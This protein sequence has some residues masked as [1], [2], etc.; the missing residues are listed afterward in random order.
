MKKFLTVLLALSV[1]FTYTVGTAFAADEVPGTTTTYQQKL[2]AAVTDLAKDLLS[3]KSGTIENLAAK[4]TETA[5]DADGHVVTLTIG[6][7]VYENV[8][9][10]VYT[11]YAK[12]LTIAKTQLEKAYADADAAG[13]EALNALTATEV[14]E[15]LIGEAVDSSVAKY[16]GMKIDDADSMAEF[17]ALV[18]STGGKDA[19]KQNAFA[20]AFQ[21]E[22][23]SVI[24]ELNKIDL[25]LYTDDVMDAEHDS[26]KTTYAQLAKNT[27]EEMI[28]DAGKIVIESDASVQTIA[29]QVY[30]LQNMIGT[31][32]LKVEEKYTGLDGNEIVVSYSLVGVKLSVTVGANTYETLLQTKEE[33]KNNDTSLE[34]QKLA[35]KA[36]AQAKAAQFYKDALDAY[37]ADKTAATKAIFDKAVTEKDA[38]LEV[39]LFRIDQLTS[40]PTATEFTYGSFNGT[41]TPN[42]DLVTEY[43]ALVDFAA[44]AKKMVEKDG[45]LTYDASKVD[46]NLAAAKIKVYDRNVATTA[47]TADIIANAKNEV[48]D[49]EFAK[50]EAVAKLESERDAKLYN[51]DD[52]DKYYDIEKT[53]INEK[54]DEVIA[55]I[56]AATT[57][58]QVD[59][60]S[61]AINTTSIHDKDGIKADVKGLSKFNSELDK[62][63]A[64]VDYLNT[65]LGSWDDGYRTL[66]AD[67]LA[68]FYAEKGARTNAEIQ[69]LLA[70]AKA[71]ADK[72]P[73]K[74]EATEAKKAV[75]KLVEALPNNI[76]LSD[77][78]AVQAAYEAAEK[79]GV[80]IDNQQRL[81]NAVIAVKKAEKNAI[82]KMVEALPALSKVTTADKATVQAIA[83]AVKAY[84]S[85]MM[86]SDTYSTTTLDKY[87]VAV[88]DAAKAEVEATIAALSDDATRT[89]IEA[90]R[91][92]Y[93]AFVKDYTDYEAGYNA[94]KAVVN[95]DK[96]LFAEAK[97]AV[98]EVKAV[99]SLKITAS[100]VAGKGYIKV[101]WTVKGDS[102]AAD[103][104]QV[105]RSTKRN[106]G[107]GTKPYFTTKN[108]TYKNTKSLKKGTRYYYKVRAYK[109]VDG[110]KVYS[111]WSNKAYRIAK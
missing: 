107:F 59:Q 98:A 55:K 10:D 37:N 54:Y 41:V 108:K 73:T 25:G 104:Y 86:Y 7:S 102:A 1:V 49:V 97:L 79:L 109:V 81:D 91:T 28:A 94:S 24:G 75:E 103:G 33:L 72:L 14:K 46:K 36:D 39:E 12:V 82:D 100:S 35:A 40:N 84:N 2:D 89:Q 16:A 31:T 38:Y 90:A 87:Q 60:I 92:A 93:D 29:G 32:K 21:S 26:Y 76:T 27:K 50:A 67:D 6:K 17:K 68:V 53:K 78:E 101:K 20:Y 65:G 77:K 52:S 111:D 85:T 8:S 83:D 11:D 19:Y 105:Y 47:T 62:V 23:D 45:S 80:S 34:A 74:K 9:G 44:V 66:T 56:K 30:K 63:N 58:A 95:L 61:K 43:E 69:A 70:E 4:Y 15:S 5:T 51:K 42:T 106:S 48:E 13:K 57:V 22:K 96:L 3:A 110:K 64:Y 18:L 88:R 71:M 99:E